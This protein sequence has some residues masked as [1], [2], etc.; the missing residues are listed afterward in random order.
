M[1]IVD[2]TCGVLVPPGDSGAL[3]GA[4]RDLVANPARRL[5]LARRRR[6]GP[7]ACVIRPSNCLSCI[8]R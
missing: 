5:A 4:L 7:G 2:D 1:E 3:A 8:V 6:L